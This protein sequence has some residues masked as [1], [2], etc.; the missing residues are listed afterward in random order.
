MHRLGKAFDPIVGL[1]CG[2][3]DNEGDEHQGENY[4]EVVVVHFRCVEA[5]DE[6]QDDKSEGG[7]EGDEAQG[8]D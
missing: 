2:E 3:D 5:V 8:N 4:R 1:K 6:N 7:N